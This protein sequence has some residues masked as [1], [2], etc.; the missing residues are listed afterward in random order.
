MFTTL[1]ETFPEGARYPEERMDTKKGEGANQ[2]ASHAPECIKQIRILVS[3]MMGGMGKIAR[4]F[5]V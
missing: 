1:L 5:P 3:V 4:E 2:Q